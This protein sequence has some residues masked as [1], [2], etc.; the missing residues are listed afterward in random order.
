MDDE[1]EHHN[2]HILG[3]KDDAMEDDIRLLQKLDI[4]SIISSLRLTI[5][6]HSRLCI[7][8]CRLVPMPMK[9]PTLSCDLTLL[10]NQFNKG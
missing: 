5:S 1:G 6:D 8:L 9:H 7:P 2:D 3:L 10:K 4:V